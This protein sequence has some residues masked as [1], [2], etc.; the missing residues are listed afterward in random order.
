MW[1]PRRVYL[2]YYCF[3]TAL[4]RLTS[5][6]VQQQ[7][8]FPIITYI[9]FTKSIHNSFKENS[10]EISDT[11]D[12]WK[13]GAVDSCS[14]RIVGCSGE[15][16][17]RMWILFLESSRLVLFPLKILSDIKTSSLTTKMSLFYRIFV[18][19]LKCFED[20]YFLIKAISRERHE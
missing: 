12:K 5:T 2:A 10:R 8:N 7:H 18:G 6:G 14:R 16:V 9:G 11:C 17:S 4:T 3:L 1:I 13:C 19:Y 20:V 15:N